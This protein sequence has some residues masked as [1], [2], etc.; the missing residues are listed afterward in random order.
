MS[1][2]GIA[3]LFHDMDSLSQTRIPPEQAF[4]HSNAKPNPLLLLLASVTVNGDLPFLCFSVPSSTTS[5]HKRLPEQTG[6]EKGKVIVNQP[7]ARMQAREAKGRVH[8]AELGQNAGEKA[9][10]K[11]EGKQLDK[12]ATRVDRVTDSSRE[13]EWDGQAAR[14]VEAL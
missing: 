13:G 1:E 5:A 8:G 11:E 7:Q 3:V 12:E 10:Q 2:L 6:A 4:K 14:K 9:I